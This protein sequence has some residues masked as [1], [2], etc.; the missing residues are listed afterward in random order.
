MTAYYCTSRI[1]G[2]FPHIGPFYHASVAF[3][4]PGEFPVLL[5][6][7]KIVSNPHCL[8][9]GTQPSVRGFLLECEERQSVRYRLAEAP[10]EVVW[11]RVMTENRRWWLL[12][13]NCKHAAR[14]AT[15]AP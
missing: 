2:R 11:C 8:Y 3:C 9:F 1:G 10:A 7:G 5:R 6:D 13:N 12:L 4:P 14:R 15:A